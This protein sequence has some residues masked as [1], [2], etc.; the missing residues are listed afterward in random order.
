MSDQD[1]DLG[2]SGAR[3]ERGVMKE[4]R[5]TFAT[6]SFGAISQILV[7]MGV[8]YRV[9][10]VEAAVTK[11]AAAGVGEEPPTKH[12]SPGKKA[13]KT[14]AKR[15]PG[16]ADRAAKG[17]QTPSAGAER[18]LEGLAR[19]GAGPSPAAGAPSGRATEGEGDARNGT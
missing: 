16:R 13:V 17:R 4:Y 18:L 10:P 11:A 12:R 6:D 1:S 3:E 19:A 8:S 14:A 5:L 7:D 15:K 2:C 9:E